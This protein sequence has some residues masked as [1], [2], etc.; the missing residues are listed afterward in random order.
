[1]SNQEASGTL[2]AMDTSA[3]DLLLDMI[4]SVAADVLAKIGDNPDA[5]F[6]FFKE[7]VAL[8]TKFAA[9]EPASH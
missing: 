3:D 9:G 6:E 2:T 4:E 5:R 8:A 1:M 7:F